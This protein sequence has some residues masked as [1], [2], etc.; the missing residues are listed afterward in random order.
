VF[1]FLTAGNFVQMWHFE[2]GLII[3]E[4]VFVLGLSLAI[5]KFNKAKVSDY[6]RFGDVSKRTLLKTVFIVILSLPIVMVLNLI[7]SYILTLFDLKVFYE[8]PMAV[9]FAGIVFQF[10]IFSVSA[11][12]CEE[13]LFRGVI[14]N[15]YSDYFDYKTAII[16]S[17]MLFG[18]FHFNV[19]NILG[20]IY[21]GIVFGYLAVKT[22]SIVPAILGHMTNNG[23]AYLLATMGSMVEVD[24]QEVEALMSPSALLDTI[25]SL[26]VVAVFSLGIV[27]FLLKSIEGP[28]L[29]QV[30]TSK[31][32]VKRSHF[33]PIMIAGVIYVAYAMLLLF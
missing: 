1:I 6:I 3:T 14:L 17:A 33:I 11:G 29:N 22:G 19:E 7:A 27:L 12:I 26:S 30:E 25:L 31:K 4:Y 10:F 2:I 16:F 13:I 28:A 20:P 8:I 18:L 32:L 23:V 9:S 21:L 24:Q 5:I 15:T